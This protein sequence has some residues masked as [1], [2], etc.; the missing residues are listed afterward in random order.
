MLKLINFPFCNLHSVLRY[1]NQKNYSYE[2]TSD[3]C[4]FSENDTIFLPGVGTFEQGMN[5]LEEIKIKSKI[6]DH[7]N[8]GGKIIAI[9]L[10]MQLLL[11][12]SEESNGIKG[13]GL[14][15]G[16]CSK[17]PESDEF[18]VPH[19]GWNSISCK[20]LKN[21]IFASLLSKDGE[22]NSD[23]YFVHSYHCAPE[24]PLITSSVVDNGQFKIAASL[25][26][27]NTYAFQFHP[28][29]SGKIG[30]SLLDLVIKI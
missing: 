5:Y 4:D 27:K 19:I 29:K 20:G 25:E 7:F 26:Y 30:Y 24:D 16:T 2:I 21:N 28:E 13:L 1:L 22:I 12:S 17:I 11:D 15:K 3:N 18:T 14:I 23:F 9:C 8:K 6:I 10:G